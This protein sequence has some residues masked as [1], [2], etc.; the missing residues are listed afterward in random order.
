ME[1]KQILN[2]LVNGDVRILTDNEFCNNISGIAYE[3]INHPN[4]DI[5]AID[6]A[7]TIIRISNIAYNNTSLEVLPL[8]D[9]LYDQLLVIYKRYNP[10]YQVGA[11]PANFDISPFSKLE[12]EPKKIMCSYIPSDQ[13]E[14]KLYANDIWR[15]HPSDFIRY[16]TLCYTVRDPITKRLINT[17]HKYPELVGTLDKCKFVLNQDAINK[18]VFNTPSVQ[19]FER[20][21]IHKCLNNNIFSP[22]EQV[23]MIAELKYD[24]ISVEAEVLGD[25]IISAYSRGDTTDNIASDLTPILGG[26]KFQNA[27]KVPKDEPFG[28]K[29]EAVITYS[30]LDKL[31]AI[32]GREYKNGRNAIIGLFGASDAYMFVD[33]ITLIPLATSFDMDR[34]AELKFLNDFYS[35]GEY[36]RYCVLRGNYQQLL[37]Q[38]KQFVESAE[39]VR[40]VLPYMIDGV[41]L[42]FTSDRIK[43]L[44]GRENS[45]NKWSM[46]IKFNPKKVRTTF[47]GYSYSI[48]KSGDVIPMVH[49]KP[50]EFIGSIHTKQTIHSY[51]RFK[52]LNLA[53]GEQID[54]EYVN[55]VL[56]YVTK[57]DNEYNRTL[58]AKPEE[59][60]KTC[61]YCGAT[62][63]I[64]P[65]GK[66][67]KCPNPHCPERAIMRM[68]D[69]ID[70][71]GFKDFAEETIR[72]LRVVT[73]RQLMNLNIDSL[74]IIGP[75][76][77]MNFLNH[78]NRIKTTPIEDYRVMSSLSFDGMADNKWKLILKQFTI[79]ELYG[80]DYDILSNNLKSISGVGPKIIEAVF[81]GMSLYRDDVDYILTNFNIINS[82]GV[83]DKPK[84]ALTGFRD[85]EYINLLINAGFDADDKYGVTKDTY[86]LI[87]NNI[88]ETSG[89]IKLA[90][91]YGIPIYSK[92][93]FLRSHNIKL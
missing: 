47:I 1:L 13:M 63:I 85:R 18:G 62:I 87:A 28:I 44:L 32:R 53:P 17:Q 73:L 41:V 91:K 70:R 83:K 42:S 51:E 50:C 15:Q 55:D 66:T 88:N 76:N 11:V 58:G 92:E 52:N 75:V 57:P 90:N 19:V 82:K 7:D 48:G 34:V 72:T 71:L 86:A 56:T 45:V 38:V 29:F 79:K 25:T 40:D 30:N 84:V 26:Y 80:M 2:Q 4:W 20:D 36:N 3:L 22:I 35:S 74:S 89:K 9:G 8:D 78:V 64:S 14:S 81:N 68:V 16:K 10:N 27:S 46:A 93:D 61:P 59:F 12:N 65:T 5:E 54:I 69:M 67:A 49:F 6:I 33:Y 21:F 24:G 31:C 43:Q 60:I 37:F 39:L 77:S 23:E